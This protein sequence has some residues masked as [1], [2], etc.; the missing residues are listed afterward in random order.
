LR[1]RAGAGAGA[2]NFIFFSE[3]I[4]EAVCE[5]FFDPAREVARKSRARS[6]RP[7]TTSI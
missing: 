4:A 2:F 1:F 6:S 7:N 3:A 5:F